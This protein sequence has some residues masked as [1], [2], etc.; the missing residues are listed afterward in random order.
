[1]VRRKYTQEECASAVASSLSYAS[2]LRKLGLCLYGSAYYSLKN[3]LREWNI[4]TEHFTGCAWNRGRTHP[5]APRISSDTLFV[6]GDVFRSSHTLRN[7]VLQEN[8]KPY[9]CEECGHP[10]LWN[11]KQLVLQLDHIDGNRLD[12]RL[13]NLRFLCPNCHTQTS[14]WCS[15]NKKTGSVAQMARRHAQDVRQRTL[16][17]DVGSTPTRVTKFPKLKLACFDC[18]EPNSRVSLR[19]KACENKNRRGKGTKIT[20]LP[21]DELVE[22]LQTTNLH[23]LGKEL[24]VSDNAIRKHLRSCGVEPPRK[25]KE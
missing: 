10:P 9:L 13:E 16:E 23:Q 8:L 12:N 4:G 2:V 6:V 21:L 25:K 7:R 20:W 15:K 22:R 14:T 11:Q 3:A 5:P 18:G 17:S 24:G 1:M 19:C